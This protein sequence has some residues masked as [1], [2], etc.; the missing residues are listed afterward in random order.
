MEFADAGW[1]RGKQPRLDSTIGDLTCGDWEIV[2][3]VIGLGLIGLESVFPGL[4]WGKRGDGVGLFSV[5]G[6]LLDDLA[7]S[8]CADVLI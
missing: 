5:C 2:R 8:S 4:V 1:Y 3:G 7:N 6:V